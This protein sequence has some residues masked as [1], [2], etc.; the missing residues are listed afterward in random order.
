MTP[1]PVPS[2]G[3]SRKA[4]YQVLSP[5]MPREEPPVTPRVSRSL[6]CPHPQSLP[7]GFRAVGTQ[8]GV[9]MQWPGVSELSGSV[10]KAASFVWIHNQSVCSS[11]LSPR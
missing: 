9:I 5:L 8:G 11:P 7:R 6:S 1:L 4:R 3:P 2:L 10:L